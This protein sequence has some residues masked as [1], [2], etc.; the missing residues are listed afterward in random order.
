[1]GGGSYAHNDRSKGGERMPYSVNYDKWLDP[2]ED[3]WC[4]AHQVCKPCYECRLEAA[5]ARD[6]E[7]NERRLID[8]G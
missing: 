5:E 6:E 7:E 8:G 4:E 3:R 1:M 2:P